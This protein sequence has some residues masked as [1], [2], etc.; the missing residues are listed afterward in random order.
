MKLFGKVRAERLLTVADVL[1][2]KG[3]DRPLPRS[4]PQSSAGPRDETVLCFP[5]PN[6]GEITSPRSE[7][8]TGDG[9]GRLKGHEEGNL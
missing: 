9:M 7:A 8:C 4:P 1:A 6:R 3:I 5:G 2:G